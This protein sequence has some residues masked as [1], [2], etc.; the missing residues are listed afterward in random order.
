VGIPSFLDGGFYSSRWIL[1]RA[2]QRDVARLHAATHESETGRIRPTKPFVM[3]GC[4]E[5]YGNSLSFLR[6]VRTASLMDVR[7]LRSMVQCA[8]WDTVFLMNNCPS[9][10]SAEDLGL[11]SQSHVHVAIFA[12]HA[13]HVVQHL[14]EAC[15]ES[16]RNRMGF[17]P[18]VHDCFT[19]LMP[20][21]NALA[22]E[23][24]L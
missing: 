20:L 15:P 22:Q 16:S 23:T 17:V 1:P 2:V 12:R 18:K 5:S 24:K 6:D 4:D 3:K 21:P 19:G 10:V 14:G 7:H 13:I 9:S 8:E 11:R